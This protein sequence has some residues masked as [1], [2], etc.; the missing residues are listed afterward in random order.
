MS[1]QYD[2]DEKGNTFALCEICDSDIIID[3][4][5]EIGDTVSCDDCGA[6]YIVRSVSPFRISLIEGEEDEAWKDLNFD[7]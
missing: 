1:R 6:F 5:S 2:M 7:D 3:F 4:Y